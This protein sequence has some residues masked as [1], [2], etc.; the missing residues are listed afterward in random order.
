MSDNNNQ[1]IAAFQ[2]SVLKEIDDKI[3]HMLANANEER[4]R[5][6]EKAKDDYLVESFRRVSNETKLIKNACR[7]RVSKQSFDSERAVLTER[8][9]LID[10]FFG[11]IEKKLKAFAVSSGYADYFKDVLKSANEKMPFYE[12]VTVQVSP[13]DY[14]KTAL[15]NDFP[16]LKAESSRKIK[17]GGMTVYY[18]NEKLYVDLTLDKQ[19]K[20]E[21]DG[22]VNNSEL[23][24]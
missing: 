3:V 19:L 7:R 14:A 10:D 2:D 15:L 23:R 6:V 11:G 5:I 18:P 4:K 21:R 12:G 24:L 17:I 1:K 9:S 22:F 20:K 16:A 8:N 13:A